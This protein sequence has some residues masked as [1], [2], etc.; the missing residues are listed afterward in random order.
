MCDDYRNRHGTFC[1]DWEEI[2]SNRV[3]CY[4]VRFDFKAI[5]QNR[6]R[7]G[8]ITGIAFMRFIGWVIFILFYSVFLFPR[9]KLFP[10]PTCSFPRSFN[11]FFSFSFSISQ[12][13]PF[14]E[15]I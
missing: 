6:R 12:L 7:R 10:D 8:L 4:Y 5:S 9:C 1:I 13:P 3:D 2:L 15:Q 14:L 11:Y